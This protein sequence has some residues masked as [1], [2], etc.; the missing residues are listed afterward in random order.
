MDMWS[1]TNLSPFMAV[2]AHW[3]ESKVEETPFGPRFKLTLRADLIGFQR[4]P[5]RHNGE[6]L[7]Q[8]FLYVIDRIAIAHKVCIPALYLS[9]FNSLRDTTI[10]RLAGLLWITQ[11]T[12]SVPLW[13]HSSMSCVV[14]ESSL[15][16]PRDACGRDKSLLFI[17]SMFISSFNSC[18]PHIVNLACKAVLGA[19][20]KVEYAAQTAEDH[21]P[22]GPQPETFWDAVSRDPIATLRSLIRAVRLYY[23]YDKPIQ[24]LIPRLKDSGIIFAA[25]AFCGCSG[26]TQANYTTIAA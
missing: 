24:Q 22:F 18:F 11:P 23:I 14:A 21:I 7:A 6:H 13:A 20:T 9:W 16:Q 19:M 1:D 3:I 12:T 17:L 26:K 4:V 25:P 2:T 8:A 10:F 5:G 15:M